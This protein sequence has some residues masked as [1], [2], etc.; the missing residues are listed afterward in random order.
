MPSV[1]LFAQDKR[2]VT[3]EQAWLGYF[4]QTR[5]NPKWGLWFDAHIRTRDD[6]FSKYSTAA[7]RIGLTY[8]L[9]DDT[10]LTAGYA[11]FN[12]FPA[13][14]HKQVSQPE[15]RSW[16]Q[17]QWQTK[18]KR[19]IAVQRLRLEQRHRR[20]IASDSALAEGYN[21]NW[22]GR[23]S[24]LLQIPLGKRSPQPNTFSLILNDEVMV[25]FG[26]QIVYNYFDQNRFFAGLSYHISPNVSLQ[27]GYMNIFQQL[28]AG[29]EYRMVHTARVFFF[30]NIDLRSN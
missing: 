18:Y 7:T 3:M 13:D 15:H 23:Y 24:Y 14:N 1:L 8:F 19:L 2:V 4:N 10:R 16:Q 26:R 25:N 28:A 29:D 20:K 21:F 12:F 17:L 5:F 11:F 9:N 22:R 30:Q 6:F 27:F